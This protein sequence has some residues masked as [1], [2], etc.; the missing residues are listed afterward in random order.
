MAAQSAIRI[1]HSAIKKSLLHFIFHKQI[2]PI[3][4]SSN[5]FAGRKVMHSPLQF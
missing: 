4:I 2:L 3:N 1:P 5:A